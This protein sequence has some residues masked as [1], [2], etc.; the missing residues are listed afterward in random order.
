MITGSSSRTPEEQ[1]RLAC[2]ELRRRL[3]AGEVCRAEEFL[4]AF[5]AVAARA[6][7]A[8][9]LILAEAAARHDLGQEPTTAEWDARF[10]HLADRLRQHLMAD[11]APGNA[12]GTLPATEVEA[13]TATR[14]NRDAAPP[15]PC[16]S[17]GRYEVLE[18]LGHGGMGR[19]FKARDTVLGR[20]VAL[21]VLRGGIAAH[22]EELFR[23][24]REAQAVA[25]LRHRHIVPVYYLGDRDGQP[26]LTMAYLPGGTLAERR[27]R[28]AGDVRASVALVEKVAR[29]VQAAHEQGVV[30]RDLK[31]GNVLLDEAGEPLVSDFGLAKVLGAGEEVTQSGQVLGTPA[32][33]APEQAAGQGHEATPASDVWALGVILYELLTGRR[34]FEGKGAELTRRVQFTR[35]AGPREINPALDRGL[36]AILLKCL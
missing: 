17:F 2:A 22:P 19:V 35:P 25:R 8:L 30:H 33:M 4:Q 28:F 36:E 9:E 23:F 15:Q 10:P 24:H 18:E 34:P 7:L 3:A 12:A 6:D 21:K 32:Y 29:A 11:A 20:L 31:P 5:P 13:A 26:Y 14:P 27:E 16:W 1:L